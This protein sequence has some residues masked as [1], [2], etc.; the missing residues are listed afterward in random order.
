MYKTGQHKYDLSPLLRLTR[1]LLS[2]RSTGWDKSRG[3]FFSNI[4]RHFRV[5]LETCRNS[6]QFN[7][8]L[9]LV[10]L[11]NVLLKLVKPVNTRVRFD[12]PL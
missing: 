5:K 12:S 3:H 2:P 6:Y 10:C 7:K 9:S 11:T 4:F 8:S 1:H